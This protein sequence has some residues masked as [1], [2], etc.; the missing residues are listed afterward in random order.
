MAGPTLLKL[1]FTKVFFIHILIDGRTH[2]TKISVNEPGNI[3]IY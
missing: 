3:A 1:V 2:F